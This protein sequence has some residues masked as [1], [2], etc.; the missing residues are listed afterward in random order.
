MPTYQKLQTITVPAGGQAAI[1]FTGI[2]SSYTDLLILL[3][4]RTSRSAVHESLLMSFNGEN[5]NRSNIRM[6]ATG[7]GALQYTSDTLMYGGQGTGATATASGFSNSMMYITSY[8]KADIK[9]SNED[10]CTE[11]NAAGALM[12]FNGNLWSNNAAIT[13][14]TLTPENGGTVQE[15]STAYL[16]GISNI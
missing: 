10:A 15:H 5:T 6:Y 12:T 11:N 8:T 14:I 9:P 3:S 4:V 16:Y 1:S 2:S 13:S 7:S